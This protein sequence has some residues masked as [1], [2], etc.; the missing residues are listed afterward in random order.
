MV[1]SSGA[2]L[3]QDDAAGALVSSLFPLATVV[4]PNLPEAEALAGS[5]GSRRELAERI[6]ALG[7]SAVIVTGGH[8]DE[9]VDHLFDG[10]EHIEI[11]VDRYDVRTTH[12]AGC[13]HSAVLTVRLARGDTL[14][15]AAIFAAA[16]TSQAVEHG[17]D[18]IGAGDGP[19]DVFNLAAAR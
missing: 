14:E 11:P 19:V 17:L 4:T 6:H 2:K 9:A 7:A 5:Q 10:R 18:A 15:E 13:T 12:G 1:A 3:L 16:A 8:G